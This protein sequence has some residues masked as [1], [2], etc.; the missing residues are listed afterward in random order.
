MAGRFNGE[1]RM[2]CRDPFIELAGYQRL[3]DVE[4]R[5]WYSPTAIVL[6]VLGLCAAGYMFW[7]LI[8][9]IV[10]APEQFALGY[11]F[12]LAAYGALFAYYHWHRF[13]NV[14]CPGCEQVMQ[15][16]VADLDGGSATRLLSRVEIGG[17]HYRPPY[18]EDDHRPWIRLMAMVRACRECKTYVS[19]SRLHYESCTDEELGLIRQRVAGV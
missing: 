9:G 1:F 6:G 18:E 10:V 15:P 8:R 13:R 14:K 19:C 2:A 7:A 16:Y 4:R 17:R 3:E 5:I 11:A 12:F